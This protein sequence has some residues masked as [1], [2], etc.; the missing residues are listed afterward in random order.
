MEPILSI[1]S[2]QCPQTIIGWYTDT[3]RGGKHGVG[4]S[5]IHSKLRGCYDNRHQKQGRNWKKGAK[6]KRRLICSR[7]PYNVHKSHRIHLNPPNLERAGK[8]KALK[9][10]I[11]QS[12]RRRWIHINPPNFSEN[13]LRR[14][15]VKSNAEEPPKRAMDLSERREGSVF[16]WERNRTLSSHRLRRASN[17][18][19]QWV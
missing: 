18:S 10:G 15:G 9:D 4:C 8:K 7:I 1:C 2:F 14:C 3:V 19:E 12:Q 17:L 13:K 16:D 5:D 11:S 6:L